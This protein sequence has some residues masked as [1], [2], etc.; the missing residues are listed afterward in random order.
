MQPFNENRVTLALLIFFT[1]GLLSRH[2]RQTTS[3]DNSRTL[4]CNCNVRLKID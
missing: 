1:L 2:R 4:P 3:C